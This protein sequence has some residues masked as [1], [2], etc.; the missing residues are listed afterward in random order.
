MKVFDYY[1]VDLMEGKKLTINKLRQLVTIILMLTYINVS[2]KEI[3]NDSINKHHN[4]TVLAF[5]QLGKVLSTNKFVSGNNEEHLPVSVFQSASLQL[6]KQTTGDKLWEQLYAFPRFGAGIYT[7]RFDDFPEIGKPVAIYGMLDLPLFRL[8]KFTINSDFGLGLT[9]N[10]RSFGQDKYN[11][12]IGAQETVYLDLGASFEYKFRNNLL[13]DLGCSFT[14]FSNGDL[15][16]PNYGI[17]LFSPKLRLGYNFHEPG[18]EFRHDVIPKFNKISEINLSVYTGWENILYKGHDVD[19]TTR[20]KGVYYP[21]YG[22]AAS[23]NR[24]ISYKSKLGFGIMADYLGA[25]NS[26]ISVIN[27]RLEDKDATFSEG[28][29]LSCFPAYSLVAGNLSIIIEE[30]FYLY[31]AKYHKRTP[32]SYQRLGLNYAVYKNISVG[33]NLRAY[34]FQTSDYIEWTLVY[35]IPLRGK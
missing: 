24:K 32:D 1:I 28:F 26:S 30:G 23:F 5:Y 15:K 21:A 33:I 13:L 3:S 31:R 18:N 14:H 9:F 11:I 2:G 20:N 7:A 27:G 4:I 29:E 16:K 12:A 10:W 17:N 6:S 34:Q 35:R 22:I 8:G 19:S 25:A